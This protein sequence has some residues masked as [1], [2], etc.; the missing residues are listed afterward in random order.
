[1]SRRLSLRQDHNDIVPVGDW[2]LFGR[3]IKGTAGDD[4]FVTNK[5]GDKIDL[6]Q[7]GS[8][9]V[10][11]GRAN[12]DV[13]FGNTFDA[14]D[15]YD[16]GDGI[17]RL[18]LSGEYAA[19]TMTRDMLVNVESINIAAKGR[20]HF[21][22]AEDV[23]G[24][25]AWRVVSLYASEAA[26]DTTVDLSALQRGALVHGSAGNDM[27]LGGSGAD[28]FY[29]RLGGRD[30]FSGG[31]GFD[32]MYF[33]DGFAGSG[34]GVSLDLRVT[35]AQTVTIGSVALRK[36]EGVEGT[37][38]ADVLTGTGSANWFVLNGGDDRVFAGAGDDLISTGAVR[39]GVKAG[40]GVIDGGR[41]I[42]LLDFNTS[43][44]ETPALHVSLAE[45]G[46]QQTGLGRY[47]IANIEGLIGSWN[48]DTFIGSRGD[49]ILIGLYAD[50]MLSGSGGNDILA[51]DGAYDVPGEETG[52]AWAIDPIGQSFSDG[53]DVLDGGAGSDSLFGAGGSDRL[54][55]GIGADEL[56]GGADEDR[57]IYADARE[58][59]GPGRDTIMDFGTG[60]RIDVSAID[61]DASRAGDQK[62]H[63]G[64][65]PGRVGDITAFYVASIDRT[66]I[67]LYLDGDSGSDMSIWLKGEVALSAA[68]FVL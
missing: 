66:V 33:G 44:G 18:Y 45:A 8:D 36:V 13:T 15:F 46:F 32:M 40:A 21:R 31:A 43:Y 24:A 47:R 54:T 56:W 9:H 37:E 51:G 59:R 20:S 57:Y 17:D 48:E 55:G 52:G 35:K 19:L 62:F 61:P 26:S 22:L 2:R 60:D 14:T 23:F 53:D 29:Y 27:V 68:D 30:S 41:G 49:D 67:A 58:S 3:S 5:G 64:A 10:S 1:M 6:S 28:D 65:T 7:G 38:A 4:T 63:F 12:D 42:D 25:G 11:T 50:D 39:S 34:Q 16:G